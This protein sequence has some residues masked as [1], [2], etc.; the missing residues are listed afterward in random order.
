MNVLRIVALAA[1]AAP[2]FTFAE[3]ELKGSPAE[4]SGYLTT[5]PGTVTITG[6]AEEKVQADR[7]L[8]TLKVAT[9]ERSLEDALENNDKARAEL[10]KKLIEKGI[11]EDRIKALSFSSTPQQGFFTDKV[12]KY[13]IEN[14]VKVTVTGDQEF[15][16]VAK[17][18]DDL[19]EVDL[20][21]IEFEHSQKDELQQKVLAKAC[22]EATALK[23]IYEKH[24]GVKLTPKRFW[25]TAVPVPRAARPPIQAAAFAKMDTLDLTSGAESSAPAFLSELEFRAEVVVEYTVTTE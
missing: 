20:G 1:L 25:P 23:A 7:A 9:E 2:A 8:V 11:A 15:R 14:F 21:N 16:A 3:P 24:L 22:D 10:T 4:L 5:V 13:K 17:L 12:K 19:D 18:V 6:D